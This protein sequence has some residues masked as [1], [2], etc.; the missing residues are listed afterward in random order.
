MLGSEF[1]FREKIPIAVIRETNLSDK[2]LV[3]LLLRHLWFKV[4]SLTNVEAYKTDIPCSL[5]I[6]AQDTGQPNDVEL[7]FAN[8]GY[9]IISNH[10]DLRL[11]PD[12]PLLVP[13]VNS[14]QLDLLKTQTRAKGKIVAI[15]NRAA[16]AAA[17]ALKPLMDNFEVDKV[18]YS[19][20][21]KSVADEII[22]ILALDGRSLKISSQSDPS[23]HSLSVK[24]KRKVS[25]EELS[26]AWDSFKGQERPYLL[27]SGY[28]HTIRYVKEGVQQE[29]EAAVRITSLRESHGDHDYSFNLSFSDNFRAAVLV[30]ELMVR[31]GYVF[32]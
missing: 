22:K 20:P 1:Y 24:F 11:E 26:Q 7:S 31:M 25:P 5:I 30:A 16:A 10:P 9:T 27:P 12:I 2:K 3:D 29:A 17:I 23:N 6:A 19:G 32:W 13:E 8:A 21:E 15:P 28:E 14:A 4:S 18:L